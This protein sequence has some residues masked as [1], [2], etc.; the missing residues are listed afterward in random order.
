M[1]LMSAA[2]PAAV[3]AVGAIAVSDVAA[4]DGGCGVGSSGCFS[5]IG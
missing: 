4:V 2:M 1:S 3:F 5:G